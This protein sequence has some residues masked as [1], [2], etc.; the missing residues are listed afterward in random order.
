MFGWMQEGR[1]D[2]AAVAAGWSGVMSLPRVV[3]AGA[4][5]SL[6]QAPAPEVDALR[7]ELLFD[8]DAAAL[9]LAHSTAISSISNSRWRSRR[10][11]PSN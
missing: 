4:D 3:S 5:G 8:G 11:A 9:S 1:T 6:H 10:A 2:A 7:T